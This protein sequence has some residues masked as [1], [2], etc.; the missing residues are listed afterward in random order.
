MRHHGFPTIA[1]VLALLLLPSAADPRAEEVTV[2]PR[3]GVDHD[4]RPIEKPAD[5]EKNHARE[6]DPCPLPAAGVKTVYRFDASGNQTLALPSTAA[7]PNWGGPN[8]IAVDADGNIYVADAG[9]TN[10]VYRFN[11]SGT[12]TLAIPADAPPTPGATP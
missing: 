7:T 12:Q 11:A 8:G 2:D 9:P 5:R 6:G 10:V 1:I 3:T 4:G